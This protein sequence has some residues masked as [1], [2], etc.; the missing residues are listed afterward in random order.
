MNSIHKIL[1]VLWISLSL[2][3]CWNVQTNSVSTSNSNHAWEITTNTSTQKWNTRITSFDEAKRDLKKIYSTENPHE[4]YCWCQIDK[5]FNTT[6]SCKYT[7][8]NTVRST[9]IEWEHINPAHTIW[10]YYWTWN[11][12]CSKW[13]NRDCAFMNDNSKYALTDLY[14]LIP[15]IWDLNLMRKDFPYWEVID[16]KMTYGCQFTLWKSRT[17]GTMVVE[18]PDI[19]K[20]ELARVALYMNNA[21]WLPF[22]KSQIDMFNRWN[23]QHP[24]SKDECLRAKLKAQI[25]WNKNPYVT[26][27]Y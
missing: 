21:Y 27:C 4:V 10:D 11:K 3:S 20:W 16:R 17:D 6:S 15:A 24:V 18:P 13:T 14:N 23:S 5:D 7:Q 26:N 12:N 25:Q 22:T 8:N 2:T 19:E 9:H 1:I